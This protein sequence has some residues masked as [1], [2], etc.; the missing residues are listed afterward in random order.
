MIP[1]NIILLMFHLFS[2]TILHV[3]TNKTKPLAI[4]EKG[5]TSSS[6]H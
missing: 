1:D 3:L 2:L 5:N 4:F 6:F